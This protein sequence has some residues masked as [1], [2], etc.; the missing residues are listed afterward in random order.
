MSQS[1]TP[2]IVPLRR[3]GQ[4]S[5]QPGGASTK[6]SGKPLLIGCVILVAG[7]ATLLLT[8]PELLK[9]IPLLKIGSGT[10]GPTTVAVVPDT[11][12]R[13]VCVAF[14]DAGSGVVPLY[15]LQPGRVTKVKAKEGVPVAAGEILMEL[16]GTLARAQLAEAEAD[17]AAGNEQIKQALLLVNQQKQMISAQQSGIEA[18]EFELLSVKAKL[19][20]L[21]QLVK[22][23]LAKPEELESATEMVRA[24]KRQ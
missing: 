9:L 22:N 23:K 21:D 10:S 5:S 11:E 20:Q 15:P 8:Q 16:D 3:P 7:I 14:V 1:T 17:V 19:R 6:S 4:T 18:K 2:R 12:E 13:V 24:G